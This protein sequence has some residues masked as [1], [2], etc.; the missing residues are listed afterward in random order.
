MNPI[1]CFK[2]SVVFV[3]ALSASI[4]LQSSCRAQE[5][6]PPPLISDGGD[7]YV[8]EDLIVLRDSLVEGVKLEADGTYTLL[9]DDSSTVFSALNSGSGAALNIEVAFARHSV[10]MTADGQQMIEAIARAIRLIG[11]EHPFILTIRHD[12]KLDPSG[13]RGLTKG[14]ANSIVQELSGRQRIKNAISIKYAG[15]SGVTDEGQSQLLAVTIVNA[16]LD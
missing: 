16:G 2:L 10:I 11:A 9:N 3:T 13:R 12:P 5:Y 7:G 1:K 8:I 14:R 4:G 6:T 15:G